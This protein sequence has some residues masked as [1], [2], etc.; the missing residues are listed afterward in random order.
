MTKAEH[1]EKIWRVMADMNITISIEFV[2]F[3]MSPLTL[4]M[5]P[6]IGWDCHIET[7]QGAMSHRYTVGTRGNEHET[8]IDSQT[9]EKVP[10]PNK[11]NVLHEVLIVAKL[12]QYYT[13]FED[14][15]KRNAGAYKEDS[16]RAFI[17]YQRIKKIAADVGELLS[18]ADRN[19][20]MTAFN[21]WG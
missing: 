12:A 13:G 14:Y 5:Q 1:S 20:L 21:D 7:P 19:R 15:Y 17:E 11:E 16:A 6:C 4:G 9:G 8:G 2:P 18:C 10:T 3:S